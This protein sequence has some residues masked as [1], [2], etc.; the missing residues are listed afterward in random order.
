MK[1]RLFFNLALCTSLVFSVNSFSPVESKALTK[2]VK[3]IENNNIEHYFTKNGIE[4]IL[5][6]IPTNNI[7]GMKV[8]IKGGSRNI[9][10]KNAGIEY[11]LV[12]TM[13]QGSKQFPKDKLTM[14]MANIGAEYTNDSFF[15]YSSLSLKSLDLYF[16]KALSI[17]QTLINDP[18]LDN[19]E[20]D[21]QKNKLLASIK[22]KIDDP[23]EYV[24][25]VV[26][27]SFSQGHP[28]Y[29]EFEGNLESIPNID[30]KQLLDY[31]KNNFVGS[32]M[33]IV[34]AGNYKNSIKKDIEKYFGS[35]PKGNYKDTPINIVKSDKSTLTIED[36][37]LPT[38]YIA[39]RFPIPTIKDSDYPATNLALK[40]L[41]QKLFET[42]RTKSGLSYAVSSG[43][44]LRAA[45][46]GYL[47]V[48]TVK[49]KE[50][51]ALMY[52]EIEKL[53]NTPVD[54]KYLEGIINLYYTQ[55]FMGLESN[56]EQANNLGLNQI[57]SGDYSNSYTLIEK[58]KKITPQDIQNA[59]KKYIK[60]IKFGIIY[61]KDLL[62]EGD[63]TKL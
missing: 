62:N 25:K 46:S 8:F 13:L 47:Y 35:I 21:L 18:L 23:D 5:K 2:E 16:D 43:S 19:K 60:N 51:V 36:R 52:Q 54:K 40:I 63:F 27:K 32:K 6:K 44:S 30:K 37:D 49:P 24:W 12:N 48:T 33:L 15:D 38:S 53:K 3:K 28:Y 58:F 4:V 45:N 26:N 42:V 34:I 59:A 7:I 57:I 1:K 17:F 50:S 41:S 20:I 10:E 11:L 14:E 31:K 29:N 56:L 39:A 55:Y 22:N 9:T 61:K